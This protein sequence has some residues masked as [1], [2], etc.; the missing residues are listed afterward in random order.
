M[1]HRGR[2][3]EPG[4]RRLSARVVRRVPPVGRPGLGGGPDALHLDCV[5]ATRTRFPL[6]GPGPE[7]DPRTDRGSGAEIENFVPQDFW[8]VHAKFRKDVAGA[9][10]EFETSHEHGPF[11]ARGEAET[12]MA[13][14]ESAP[15]G[16]VRE[17]L[18]NER[19]E[20][21]PPPFNTTMFAAESNRIGFGAAQAMRIAEDL[22]QSGFISYPRTDN[23]V[24][25]STINLRSV[26]EKLHESPFAAEARERAG[27]E[28]SVPSRGRTEAT[29]HPP[30]YP[31]QGVGRDKVKREDHWRIYELVVRRFFAT[32]AP[33]AVAEAAEA[34][35]D[36][37]GEMFLAE[38]YRAKELGWRKY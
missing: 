5:E 33:N 35:I 2:V 12:A 19:E 24:Y 27:Q 8:T 11:W 22:Y 9:S 6:R 13:Q 36:L 3:R 25:P 32:V 31:V 37:G 15:Q 16:L 20:R 4:G 21:P 10:I 18:Q 14:A 38:G 34:K 30:I 26:L 28:R 23:T 1:G 17:Y 29:D 7:P